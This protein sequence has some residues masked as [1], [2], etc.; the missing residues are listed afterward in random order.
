MSNEVNFSGSALSSY[1]Q[2]LYELAE[3]D[4]C[5]SEI[6][7]QVSNLMILVS[8]NK[9]FDTFIKDPTNK[10]SDLTSVMKK[11]CE[12]FEFNVLFNKFLNFLVL[13]RRLFYLEKILN[14][15]LN[16]CSKKR[17][18]VVAKLTTAKELNNS[19]I[20]KIR[21]ELTQNFGKNIKLDY[22]YDTSLIGGLTI[23]VGSVM[24]DTSIKNKLKQIE[25]K[26]LEK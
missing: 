6:E 24:V 2:A 4:N 3:E 20:E 9:D 13:K 10:N 15:F 5:V 1:A 7:K 11:I 8:Q 21:N 14:D 17:G 26:M 18:E 19:E 22:K 12:K 16:I 25:N 23:Q